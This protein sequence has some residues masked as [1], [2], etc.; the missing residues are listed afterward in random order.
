VND[1]EILGVDNTLFAAG[2]FSE[3]RRFYAETLGLPVKFEIAAMGLAAFRLG[4]EEPGLLVRTGAGRPRLWLEVRDARA[5][6]M[7]L[8]ARGVKLLAPPFEVATGWT[9]EFEDP[10][11]NVLGLTDYSKDPAQGRPSRS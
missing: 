2:D 1:L 3:A 11:G 7:E 5:S 6:A 10:W 4:A 8:E 9:V